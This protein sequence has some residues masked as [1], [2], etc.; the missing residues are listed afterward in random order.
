VI[1]LSALFGAISAISGLIISIIFGLTPAPAMTIVAT[2]IYLLA[3]LFAPESGVVPSFRLKQRESARI[4]R[5]DIIKQIFKKPVIDGMPIA[6]IAENLNQSMSKIN[7]TVNALSRS[8]LLTTQ[9]NTV[10]LSQDGVD[11]AEKL[12]RAHRLWET[13]QVTQMGLRSD[14]IHEEAERLEHFLSEE[15]VD[16][17]EKE[18]GYP[19]TDPHDSPIPSK[20]IKEVKI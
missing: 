13:Y 17:I 16:E 15:L 1:I 7:S 6:A 3:V 18:L 2:S 4:L 14:Q 12:V 9:G 8:R 5:E 10:I 20:K 19:T 11:K